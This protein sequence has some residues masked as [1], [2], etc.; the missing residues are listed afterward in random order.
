MHQVVE[1]WWRHLPMEKMI[2]LAAIP[3]VASWLLL[4]SYWVWRRRYPAPRA[5]G[6]ASAGE[7]LSARNLGMGLFLGRLAVG[8]RWPL[9]LGAMVVGYRQVINRASLFDDAFIAFRYSRNFAEGHGLV[10]NLGERVEGYTNFLW[11]LI[12]GI[13]HRV[14]PLEVP[15]LALV[16]GLLCF[17]ANLLVV[18]RLGQ[19]LTARRA[20]DAGQGGRSLHLPLAVLLLALHGVYT[21]YGTSGLE[22]G[23]ASLC[24]NLGVLWL[25]SRRT[26]SGAAIAGA[27]F[28]AAA[29]TRPDHGLFYALGGLTLLIDRLR[30]LLAARRGGRTALWRA[31]GDVLTAYAAPFLVYVVYLVWKFAYYG[32]IVPNTYYAKSVALAWY[33]QGR[34]YAAV[35]YLG[36]QAWAPLLLCLVWL[37]RRP[38]HATACRFRFFFATSFVAYN[39]YV[40]KLG[41][42]FMYG[43]FYVT[44]VPLYLLAAEA[45]IHELARPSAPNARRCLRWT[46]VAAALGLLAA[47]T[48]AVT[49][50]GPH[51]IRWRIADEATYHFVKSFHPLSVDHHQEPVGK[52]FRRVLKDRGLDVVLGTGGPGTV[53]Y[54]SRL[55][56]IDVR[57]LTDAYVARQRIDKRTRP[58]HEKLAPREYLLARGVHLL[59]TNAGQEEFHPTRWRRMTRVGLGRFPGKDPWQ[60]AHYDREL[61]RRIRKQAPELRF[62][63]FEVWLDRYIEALPGRREYLVRRDLEWMR[64]YYFDHNEDPERLA[65]IEAHIPSSGA[66]ASNRES[67]R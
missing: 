1:V 33:P 34:I 27:M 28:I 24:V 32:D 51:K 39:L 61:M 5:S 30:S 12:L 42:D 38:R 17:G 3:V 14:T 10:F 41:G 36:T 9:I 20:E 48:Q 52:F 19:L 67:S 54:H 25:I 59:R 63:D 44:L 57:G 11:T 18:A 43:R 50:I 16:L 29:L 56:V 40:A 58:G 8:L 46:A 64:G 47:S 21:D 6:A 4:A 37:L 31:G 35:F 55:P 23:A 26:A 65:A 45:L 15:Q 49:M 7:A 66:S 13:L 2:L 22:T 62:V 60:L 53:G